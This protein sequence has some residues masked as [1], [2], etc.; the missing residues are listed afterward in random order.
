MK[1]LLIAFV[2][3]CTINAQAGLRI[4]S[5]FDDTIK[6]SNIPDAGW[7]TVGNAAMFLK[8]YAGMPELLQELEEKS[9]GLYVLSASPSIIEFLI[10]G[11]M[12]SYNIPYVDIFTR[13]RLTD[14]GSEAN[15]IRYK[16]SR[17]T[18]VL[19]G[20]TDKVILLGD[21][22]EADHKVYKMLE[23]THAQRIEYI[24]IRRVVNKE[25]LP[26]GVIG[27]FTAFDIAAQ[28]YDN[29]R[30]SFLEVQRVVNAIVS[31]EDE[32]MYRLLPGYAFCPTKRE[33]FRKVSSP[34]LKIQERMV[35]NRVIDY[36]KRRSSIVPLI[37]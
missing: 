8:A 5:D 30:L 25:K 29:G 35:Q 27:F 24:Y 31:L 23:R 11:T 36:C 7:R 22:V 1:K 4:V 3:F 28:E 37:D 33:D 12:K 13:T 9:N 18:R 16:L 14:F 6:R 17:L 32:K 19:D 20:N 21:D 10:K 2:C 15:K 34:V 26:D